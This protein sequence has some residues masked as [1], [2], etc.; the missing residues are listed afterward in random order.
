L[1]PQPEPVLRS[2]AVRGTWKRPVAASGPHRA[3]HLRPGRQRFAGARP[4]PR[5]AALERLGV[6]AD[7]T[8]R[9]ETTPRQEGEAAGGSGILTVTEERRGARPSAQPFRDRSGRGEPSF[10]AE[11]PQP[12]EN[13]TLFR[14]G[15]RP[16][17]SPGRN[18]A[19]EPPP[20]AAIPPGLRCS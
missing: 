7:E 15:T 3:G 10:L 6:R 16:R 17:S 4:V 12:W 18:E 13:G 8:R 5:R 1:R 14:R 9:G 20:A 19:Q 11:G 2:A